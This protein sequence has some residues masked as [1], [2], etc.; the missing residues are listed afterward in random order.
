M[1]HDTPPPAELARQ[2]LILGFV[3]AALVGM[4]I[5]VLTIVPNL[6]L[7]LR[8]FVAATDLIL[9]AVL[10]LVLRQKFSGK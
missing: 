1:H 9:A 3:I 10:A 2:K 4:A 7:P 5:L 6:A 8:I